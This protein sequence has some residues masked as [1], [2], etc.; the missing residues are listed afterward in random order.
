[1][2]DRVLKVFPCVKQEKI[3]LSLSPERKAKQAIKILR[4]KKSRFETSLTRLF[5]RILEQSFPFSHWKISVRERLTWFYYD[6]E[7]RRKKDE[8]S[9]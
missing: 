3:V 1:M 9:E 7:D 8:E 2:R 6:E 5:C 4:L